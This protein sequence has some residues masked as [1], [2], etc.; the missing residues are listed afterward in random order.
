VAAQWSSDTRTSMAKEVAKL[1]VGE[2]KSLSA[3]SETAK[4]CWGRVEDASLPAL[5]A[6]QDP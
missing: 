2:E 3:R 6:R 5:L 4:L 1:G